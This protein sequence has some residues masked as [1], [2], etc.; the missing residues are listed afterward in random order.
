MRE[1]VVVISNPSGLHLRPASQFVRTAAGYQSDIKVRNMSRD[2]GF[3]NAKSAIGVMMLKAT[4]GHE[5]LIRADGDDEDEAING[6]CR[7]IENGLN[8]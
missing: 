3:Q 5:L 4:Q 6:L 7:L 1:I 8:E 2:S